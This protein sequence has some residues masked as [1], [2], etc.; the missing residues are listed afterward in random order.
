MPCRNAWDGVLKIDRLDFSSAGG[1]E[2]SKADAGTAE[3]IDSPDTR[4]KAKPRNEG[5]DFLL[6]RTAAGLRR[7]VLETPRRSIGP[8]SYMPS[9]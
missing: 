6:T 8:R 7:D 2:P 1:S 9:C 5:I 4:T 3:Q